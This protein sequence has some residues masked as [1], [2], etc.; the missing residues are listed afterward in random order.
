MQLRRLIANLKYTCAMYLLFGGVPATL[1]LILYKLNRARRI[2]LSLS[3]L[4]YRLFE[5]F[6]FPLG[7]DSNLFSRVLAN[8]IKPLWELNG[9]KILFDCSQET[10]HQLLN[11]VSPNPLLFAL[12]PHGEFSS[13]CVFFLISFARAHR[14]HSFQLVHCFK[15]V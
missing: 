4:V 6:C 9:G 15:P 14:S 13:F 10:K 12:S 1:V 8:L 7:L 5:S 3:Y 2:Q 11:Q